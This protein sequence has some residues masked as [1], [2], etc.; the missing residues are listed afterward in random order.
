MTNELKLYL[1]HI[2]QSL[3]TGAAT[4]HTHRP[5]LATLLET[6][7][8]I[9]AINEP[10]HIACGAPDLA[11]LK[12][13][14]LAGHIEAKDIG[15][16]L[17]AVERTPQLKR[18]LD[19]LPNLILTDYLEFRWYVDGAHRQ[20]A[21]LATLDRNNRLKSTNDDVQA[22]GDLLNNYLDH[23]PQSIATPR[24]LAE[25]M[26][27]LA[28]LIRDIIV[29]AFETDHASDLL[30]GWRTA[31][32]QVLVAD[33]DQP[34]KTGEFADMF[35]QT[36]A[37]G[38]FSARVMDDTPQTFTRAEAQRLIP[39]TNPFLRDFFYQITGPQLENEPF[40]GF[41]E[42]LVQLLA[43]ADMGAILEDFGR[44]TRQ[45]D[46]TVHFYETFLA[47]YDPRL[48]AARGV[49]YTPD[50]V[51]SF[52]VR[53]VDQ[54]LKTKF[55]LPMGLADTS[56]VTVKNTDPGLRV[57]GKETQ[58]RKTTEIHKVLILDPATGT[59]TFPYAI[60]DH[61]RA[62]FMQQGNAGMW[63]GYVREHLLPRIFG[64]EL[65]MA[66]Y[67][68]AH[69]KLALQLAGHDLDPEL[70]AQWAYDFAS[71]ERIGIYLT[72]AL[73]GPHEH[74]GLPLFTQFLADESAAANEIKQDTPIM[75][76]VGNPPYSVSSSNQGDHIQELMALYKTA[77]RSERNIQPLSDDYIKFIRFAHD[78]IERTGYG[79]LGF[80]T[81]HSYLAGLIHRGMR[82]ELLKTFDEIYIVNLHGNALLGET[83]PDGGKDENVFDIRQGVA[84]ALMV[85][86]GKGNGLAT[87]HY[88]DLWGERES[89]YSVLSA[90]DVNTLTWETLQPTAPHYFFVPK[91][92]GLQGEYEKEWSL[93]SVFGTGNP[94]NDQ[95]KHYGSGVKTNRDALLVDFERSD[96]EQ[97]IQILADLELTDE[98][99]KHKFG[100]I[101]SNYWN[102]NRE[103]DKIR[104]V[105]WRANII[106][107]L[108]R[109]FDKRW[110]FYQP[111]LIEIGRGGA[112]K[113][114][115]FHILQSNLALCT[116]R[117]VVGDEFQH[118]FV[119]QTVNDMNLL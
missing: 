95:G 39:R 81:N 37:Y 18:Y 5:A 58:V 4:E 118:I 42:D 41:V 19:A 92:F 84:I 107:Y 67:A 66:P 10:A 103:R 99:V 40:T 86:T 114:V 3:A 16:D 113:F 105:N 71:D 98:D 76:V 9:H 68:V 82:E 32:A 57:K 15:A 80:I 43:H 77:V 25:R 61:I 24:E 54:L 116:M 112:S 34:E 26:A 72:N 79:I 48:R 60:V 14:F 70:R 90:N 89:K 49:F 104:A 36:L 64:F 13:G 83:T 21:R 87:V 22:V 12:D 65:L 2:R 28:H 62:Q 75:V 17:N 53:S 115:M 47:A 96:L 30:R 56:K 97:R 102:T 7:P 20:T 23:T 73:E 33:L 51:V 59:A 93:I 55:D 101:D 8:G 38:L 91:D 50:P 45:Q 69:F 27:H 35:A 29:T 74:T 85:K 119:S 117:Q 31:F 100:L 88:A 109:P 111:N 44:R 106:P 52:I 6:F 78:R 11:V 46:P 94:R 110:A 1:T 63:S 108:H